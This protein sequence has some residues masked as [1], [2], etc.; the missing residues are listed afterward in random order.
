MTHNYQFPAKIIK[1]II[2]E[3]TDSKLARLRQESGATYMYYDEFKEMVSKHRATIR[4]LE[5]LEDID[6]WLR[7]YRRISLEEWVNT[8]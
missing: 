7:E 8:L 1:R 6:D 4:D 2:L 3:E 5:T